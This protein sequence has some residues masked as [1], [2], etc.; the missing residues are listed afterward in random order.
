[1]PTLLLLL[2]ALT[3]SPLEEPTSAPA[4]KA[5]VRALLAAAQGMAPAICAMAADGASGWARQGTLW[6]TAESPQCR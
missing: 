1:M 3:V 5:D 6:G 4:G 2:A